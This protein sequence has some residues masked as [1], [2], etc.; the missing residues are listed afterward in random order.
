MD[1]FCCIIL[2][3]VMLTLFQP[4]S[5][6]GEGIQCEG[7]GGVSSD[8]D[9]IT[10]SLDKTRARNRK[11]KKIED[12]TKAKITWKPNLQNENISS[13]DMSKLE[14][15]YRTNDKWTTFKPK[16]KPSFHGKYVWTVPRIPCMQYEYQIVVPA[17]PESDSTNCFTTK[18]KTLPATSKD[19]IRA[20]QFQPDPPKGFEITQGFHDGN[21]V[22]VVWNNSPCADAYEVYV[23]EAI[24][25]IQISEHT[26]EQ[27][28]DDDKSNVLLSN[29]RS[30]TKYRVDIHPKVLGGGIGD[31]SSDVYFHTK[32]EDSSADYLDLD[33]VISDKNSIRLQF[34][35][36]AEK[37]NCLEDFIIHTCSKD[38]N[39][40]SEEKI[41]SDNTLSAAKYT[42]KG[43]QHCTK[44]FLKVQPTYPTD[45][46]VNMKAR[47]IP[48]I[49]KF[50]ETANNFSFTV[51]PDITS[52]EIFAQNIDCTDSYTLDYV[53]FGKSGEKHEWKNKTGKTNDGVIVIENLQPKSDYL[54][55]MAVRVVGASGEKD[56]I[57]TLP[58]AK[59]QTKELGYLA[60]RLANLESKEYEIV[61]QINLSTKSNYKNASIM[62]YVASST[63]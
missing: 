39:C 3:A 20:A 34:F 27:S 25:E 53:L 29:L 61:L 8:E 59:F 43:L 62:I 2:L 17:K 31:L 45:P 56:V 13:F 26:V 30:C 28:E 21:D 60:P 49:T 33:N 15:K 54:V 16:K 51:K 40:F 1:K 18:I 7:S 44:Y 4:S 19:S 10:V 37:V 57:L 12:I 11:A 38:G 36:Y 23:E 41:K 42:I 48:V 14:L 63:L 24:D 58:S 35:T 55:N 47:R 46:N 6:Y 22:T 50:D 52:A 32:P 5:I 9:D